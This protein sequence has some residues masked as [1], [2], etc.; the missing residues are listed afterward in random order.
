M[1]RI[2]GM[3]GKTIRKFKLCSIAIRLISI[4]VKLLKRLFCCVCVAPPS[5]VRVA[6]RQWHAHFLGLV[7]ETLIG[8]MAKEIYMYGK[9]DL[10]VWQKRPSCVIFASEFVGP[11]QSQQSS[12]KR[13]FRLVKWNAHLLRLVSETCCTTSVKHLLRLGTNRKSHVQHSG[14]LTKF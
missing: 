2:W 13:Y 5:S 4:S 14:T 10:Y 11:C 7:S 8:R 6:P 3:C 1:F 12:V 9:R